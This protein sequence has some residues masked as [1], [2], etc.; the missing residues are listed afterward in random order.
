MNDQ[1]RADWIISDRQLLPVRHHCYRWLFNRTVQCFNPNYNLQNGL[2][3]SN[4]TNCVK[5]AD[6]KQTIII[7]Q[8]P[9]FF[10]GK[11]IEKYDL[12]VLY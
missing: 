12:L 2:Q 5:L 7:K 4:I 6:R 8:F 1:L 10:L 9:Q 3:T 11:S